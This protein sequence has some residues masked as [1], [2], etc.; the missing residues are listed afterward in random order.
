MSFQIRS[1]IGG[2][3]AVKRFQKPF[4][5]I[6]SLKP[7]LILK[8]FLSVNGLVFAILM[9][10]IINSSSNVI[11]D[12]IQRQRY[13]ELLQLE[14]R[15]N[16]N[17][18]KT[19]IQQFEKD[20]VILIRRSFRSEVFDSGLQSGYLLSIDPKVLAGIYVLYTTYLPSVNN[21]VEHQSGIIEDY[22]TVWEK[23]VFDLDLPKSIGKSNCDDEKRV[24]KAVEKFYSESIYNHIK[25]AEKS[26]WDTSIKFNPTQDRL[27]SPILRLFMGTDRLKIQE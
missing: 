12:K 3:L 8:W 21:L 27:N 17:Q 25:Q 20:G 9:G 18:A 14:M 1:Y 6:S 15:M 23:C 10:I 24:F 13:L 11:Q 5:R 7:S 19:D 22:L 4:Q 2:L 16:H 26:L